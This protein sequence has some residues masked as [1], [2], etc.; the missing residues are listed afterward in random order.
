M[1]KVL[2]GILILALAFCFGGCSKK[3]DC[4]LCRKQNVNV[5]E[6]LIKTVTAYVCDDCADEIAELKARAEWENSLW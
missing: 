6:V 4:A 1:K 2:V 3:G 5:E